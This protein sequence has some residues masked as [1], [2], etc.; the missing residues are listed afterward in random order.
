M[1]AGESGELIERLRL[2]QPDP[3]IADEQEEAARA[4][5]LAV[6]EKQEAVRKSRSRAELFLWGFF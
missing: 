5:E 2:Q 3:P 6:A 4:G 1:V